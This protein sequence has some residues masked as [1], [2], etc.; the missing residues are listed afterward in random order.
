MCGSKLQGLVLM[1]QA[2]A[3]VLE[4]DARRVTRR[5]FRGRP[6]RVLGPCSLLPDSRQMFLVR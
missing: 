4:R 6:V 2:D 5:I 3:T 1:L